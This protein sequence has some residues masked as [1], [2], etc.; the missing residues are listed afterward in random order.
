LRVTLVFSC[1]P[2]VWAVRALFNRDASGRA[3]RQLVAAPTDI[4]AVIDERYD[5]GGDALLDVYVPEDAAASGTS[6]PVLVW[7][8]GG[9]F[10]GGS[11]DE[12]GGYFRM[13]A[14][15]GLPS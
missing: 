12:L 8:H 4:V 1:K 14:G 6:L 11:K 15:H 5:D 13:L 9:A 10:V 7:V 2:T 3:A